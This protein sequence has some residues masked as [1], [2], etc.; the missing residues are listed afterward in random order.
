MVLPH[1]YAPS[2]FQAHKSA[3]RRIAYLHSDDVYDKGETFGRHKSRKADVLHHIVPSTQPIENAFDDLAKKLG[4][5]ALELLVVNSHGQSSYSIIGKGNMTPDKA[6]HFKTFRPFFMRASKIAGIEIHSCLFASAVECWP[7]KYGW[8]RENLML[9]VD[10]VEA[11][12]GMNHLNWKDEDK[13]A[14]WTPVKREIGKG[15]DTMLKIARAANCPVKA[16]FGYQQQDQTG[17]FDTPWVCARPNG[18]I[19]F[20]A[21]KISPDLVP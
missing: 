8:T 7:K 15:T 1:T 6:V 19:T 9:F 13:E 5:D 18:K 14:H 10:S 4:G 2:K 12:V 11:M 16:G 20:H 17:I 21:A 3:R